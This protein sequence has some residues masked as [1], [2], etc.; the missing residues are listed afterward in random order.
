M[1]PEPGNTGYYFM[2]LPE[3]VVRLDIHLQR[4]VRQEYNESYDENVLEFHETGLVGKY[5]KERGLGKRAGRQAARY[6]SLWH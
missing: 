1:H 2:L 6:T 5:T 3:V 4:L